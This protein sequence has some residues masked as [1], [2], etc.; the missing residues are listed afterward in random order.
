MAKIFIRVLDGQGKPQDY[1]EVTV[2]WSSG[3]TSSRRTNSEGLAN[4]D[5]DGPRTA[6]YV[7]VNGEYHLQNAV[8]DG[9]HTVHTRTY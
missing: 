6:E 9:E 1:R 3:G 7:S 2:K 8:L 5:V 4:L